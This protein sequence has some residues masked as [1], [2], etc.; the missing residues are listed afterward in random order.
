MNIDEL[1]ADLLHPQVKLAGSAKPSLVDTIVAA[2]QSGDSNVLSAVLNTS[3]D[4]LNRAFSDGKILAALMDNYTPTAHDQLLKKGFDVC[5]F[6]EDVLFTHLNATRWGAFFRHTP[7]TKALDAW[8]KNLFQ[9]SLDYEFEKR[10]PLCKAAAAV[11]RTVLRQYDPVLHDKELKVFFDNCGGVEGLLPRT[12]AQ[13][14]ACSPEEWAW[15]K[16][17]DKHS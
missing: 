17:I 1:R 4:K 14:N 2:L 5:D 12:L 11:F 6:S 15:L 16:S 3:S 7:K 8:L 9:E 10:Y 13:L